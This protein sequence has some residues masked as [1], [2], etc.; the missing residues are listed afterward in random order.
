MS[1]SPPLRP[2]VLEPRLDL[3]VR[4][5]EG[6]SQRSALRRGEVLLPM[7]ALLQLG[8]LQPGERSAGLLALGRRPVLVGVAD[9]PRHGEGGC[10]RYSSLADSSHTRHSLC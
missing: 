4:H 2:P 5:L 3:R 10:N 6:L 7:K 8:D 1:N 9:P